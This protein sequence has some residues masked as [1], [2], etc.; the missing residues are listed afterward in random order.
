MQ[1]G[2]PVGASLTG[3][4]HGSDLLSES[5]HNDALSVYARLSALSALPITNVLADVVLAPGVYTSPAF[6]L[7]VGTLTFDGLNNPN[8]TWIMISPGYL[9]VSALGSMTL[10]NGASANHIFWALGDYASFGR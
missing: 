4:N 5:A 7:A 6:L 8:S 2:E 10:I 9:S 1:P 3:V